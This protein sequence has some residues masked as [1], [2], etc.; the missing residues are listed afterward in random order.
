M[1][2]AR[3]PLYNEAMRRC[4]DKRVFDLHQEAHLN[5]VQY[6]TRRT[7]LTHLRE[8]RNLREKGDIEVKFSFLKVFE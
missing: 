8:I 6:Q 5:R 3:S 2:Q 4:R 7:M 1:L